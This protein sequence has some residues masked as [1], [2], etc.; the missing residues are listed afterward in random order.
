VAGLDIGSRSIELV[1]LEGEHLVEWAKV[2]TTFDP[3]GQCRRLL[4]DLPPARLI[5]TGY[6][7]KLAQ[8]NLEDRQ[9][10]VITEI[11]AYALGARHLAPETRTVLDIGGQDTKVIALTPDGKVAKFEMNDRCAA[12]TGKFLEFMAT[13]LQIP[14]EEFGS[15]ALA[16]RKTPADQQYV[17]GVCRKRGHLPHGPG[18]VPRQHRDGPAPGHCAAHL[19]HAPPGQRD[20]ALSLCRGC[21]SQCLHPHSLGRATP[22][23]PHHS[24]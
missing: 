10:T 7:R 24:G 11:Q 5:A 4:R 22:P 16:G 21:G 3:L 12:G 1:L 17:H 13:A 15:F 20:S 14:L 19:G 6:G 18:R 8:E 23:A 2:P 9:V